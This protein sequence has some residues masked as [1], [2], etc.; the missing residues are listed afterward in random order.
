MTSSAPYQENPPGR[1]EVALAI[2]ENLS[3]F[4][5]ILALLDGLRHPPVPSPGDPELRAG[6]ERAITALLSAIA[7]LRSA[8]SR[9]GKAGKEERAIYALIRGRKAQELID[10]DQLARLDSFVSLLLPE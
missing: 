2:R 3:R 7:P 10:P 5:L 1:E 6:C 4:P 9:A 8:V